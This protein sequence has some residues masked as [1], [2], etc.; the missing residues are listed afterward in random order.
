MTYQGIDTAARI[1]AEQ[2]TKLAKNGIAFAGRYL[3]PLGMGKEITDA[4]IETLQK[5]GLAILLCWEVGAEA[6]KK[7]AAQG[8]H[9]ATRAKDLAQAFGVPTGTCIY[10]AADYNV[11]QADYI[12]CEQYMLAARSALGSKY[13]A[14]LYGP[15]GIVDFLS[16]RRSCRKFWQCVAWSNGFS[17]SAT[18]QQY[19]W[20]GDQRAKEMAAK[21]GILAVDLDQTDDMRGA[22]LWMPNFTEYDDGEGG[23]IIEPSKPSAQAKPWYADAMEW[24][25]K[26]GLIRDGRPLDNLTRAEM[27]T[28]LQRYDAVLEQKVLEAV[29]RRLPDDDSLGGL[30]G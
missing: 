18:V 8:V 19:A 24:A 17:E 25:E 2:A 11:P 10:F 28:I 13:E 5:A 15:R 1:T 27:A 7:G 21:T 14:G 3:V 4:E 20:Q 6:V 16:S 23:T 9:D 26:T 30:I 29:M 12:Q 22:G